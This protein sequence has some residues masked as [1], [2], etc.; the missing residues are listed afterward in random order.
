MELT[1]K[2]KEDPSDSRIGFSFVFSFQLPEC[3]KWIAR[4]TCKLVFACQSEELC[5]VPHKVVWC[6]V[7]T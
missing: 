7:Y 3:L 6:I 2:Y 1:V 5:C 4:T